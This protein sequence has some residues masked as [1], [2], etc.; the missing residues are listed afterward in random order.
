MSQRAAELTARIERAGQLG[1]VVG[2][3]RGIA[4][5]HA[6]QGQ[7]RLRGVHAYANTVADA[8]AAAVAASE[9]PAA[10]AH[11]GQRIV[12]AFGAEQGFAGVFSERVFDALPAHYDALFVIGRRALRAA[13]TR[14]LKPDWSAPA[15]AHANGAGALAERLASA[16]FD[17]LA[18]GTADTVDLLYP[19]PVSASA[20]QIVQTPLLPL[21]WSRFRRAQHRPPPLL[22]LPPQQLLQQL[23]SEYLLAQLTEAALQSFTAENNA[24]TRA[25]G[26]ARDNISQALDGLQREARIA[27]QDAITAEVVELAAGTEAL[28]AGAV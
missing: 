21:D 2:A 15:I 25:M 10:T 16:V 5:A 22:Q 8:I 1:A 3:L 26:A 12:I 4:A 18:A 13:A 27:R 19:A 6:Q 7:A 28:N 17:R 20:E 9:Q 11:H 24:R 23:A 14:G